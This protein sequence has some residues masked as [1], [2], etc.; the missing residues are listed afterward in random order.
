VDGNIPGPLTAE[1]DFEVWFD[2]VHRDTNNNFDGSFE[3]FAAASPQDDI[4]KKSN[5][6]R[7]NE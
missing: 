7:R 2:S 6:L 5:E 3:T 1:N 4:V